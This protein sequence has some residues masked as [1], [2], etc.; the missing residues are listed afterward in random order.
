MGDEGGEH[1]KGMRKSGH[2]N[3]FLLLRLRERLEKQE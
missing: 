3:T 1:K 2:I